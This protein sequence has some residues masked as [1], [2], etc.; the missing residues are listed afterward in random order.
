MDIKVR[1]YATLRDLTETPQTTVHTEGN[2][3]GDVFRVLINKYGCKFKE[4][5]LHPDGS[6]KQNVKLF[7]NGVNINQIAPLQNV[8]KEGDT[9][10]IFPPIIGG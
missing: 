5:M 7:I 6:I 4:E 3:I 1:F 2:T 9:L 10:Y 8:V